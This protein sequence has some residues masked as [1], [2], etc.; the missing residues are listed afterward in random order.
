MI[1]DTSALIAILRQEADAEAL[2]EAL[3]G[4]RDASMSAGTLIEVTIVID[5]VGDPVLSGRFDD[6]LVAAQVRIEPVT[7]AQTHLARRADASFGKG[8]GHPAGLNFGDCF[9]YALA[10][11]R[12]ESLL[13]K[14]DD[15]SHT[16]IEAVPIR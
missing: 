2:M 10:R 11:E 12:R 6:L 8:S 5:A 3:A 15:F 13:F 16:D 9:A 4:A 14:G 1:V 7:D